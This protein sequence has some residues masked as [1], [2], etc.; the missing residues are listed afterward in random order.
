[1]CASHMGVAVPADSDSLR[2]EDHMRRL[3]LST[4]VIT[5]FLL[6]A[7]GASAAE[8]AKVPGPP[9]IAWKDMKPEQ[10]G[11]FMKEVVV[12]KMRDAFQQFDA[13]EFKKFGCPTCHGK[14]PKARKFKMPNP[15]IY[16]LPANKAGF[17]AIK[18]K[19][20][21]ELKFMGEVVKPQ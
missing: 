12:P 6:M 16:V 2:R 18:E 21:K 4:F 5:S 14:D 8:P 15:D 20:A 9:D 17:D 1:M 3:P 7:R 11:K 10:R 13:K 19:K